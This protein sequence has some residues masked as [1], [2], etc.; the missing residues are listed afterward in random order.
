MWSEALQ[1]EAHSILDG[2]ASDHPTPLAFAEGRYLKC[3]TLR[4][5]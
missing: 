2:A 1:R 3:A 4:I 5:T